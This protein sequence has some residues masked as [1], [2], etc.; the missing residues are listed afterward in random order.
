MPAPYKV[1]SQLQAFLD[2]L[3]ETGDERRFGVMDLCK[4]AM[5][6]LDEYLEDRPGDGAVVRDVVLA[7]IGKAQRAVGL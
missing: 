3:P 6:A 4:Q 5:D 1:L 7:R 2:N